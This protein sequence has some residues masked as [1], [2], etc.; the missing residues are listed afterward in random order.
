MYFDSMIPDAECF[1]GSMVILEKFVTQKYKTL[2]NIII[3]YK[4]PE[5]N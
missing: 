5:T 1:T 4:N 3:L 2:S